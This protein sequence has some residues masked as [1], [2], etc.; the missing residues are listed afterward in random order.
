MQHAWGRV[1]VRAARRSSR[2]TLVT[3]SVACQLRS[4]A[5]SHV[6]RCTGA[7][8]FES[9]ESTPTPSRFLDLADDDKAKTDDDAQEGGDAE[10]SAEDVDGEG[11]DG[12]VEAD[13]IADVN[14]GGVE[15]NDE[16]DELVMELF[17]ENPLKW[18]PTVLARKFHLAKAR[19]EAIIWMKR[20]EAE[21][22][23]DEF[24]AKVQEAKDK[25][26]KETQ[27][28]AKKLKDAEAAGNE[29][30]VARLTKRARQEEDATKPDEE[31]SASEEAVLMGHDDEA[32]RNPDFFFLSDE[33]E[34]YP[35]LV[36]RMGK[37]G[38]TDQVY[39]E[40]ALELQRLAGNN[41]IT[42]QKSF[43]NPKNGESKAKF[44]LAVK[45][46][47]TKKK[48]LLVRDESRTLRL[49]TNEEVLPRTWVRRPA[50]FR[51]LD[52]ELA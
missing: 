6:A 50:Y 49:A 7:V 48:H 43:A 28:Q 40:E 12:D 47:T 34:G 26:Q 25:A 20:M 10:E 29:K 46:I 32:F 31:L 36:R 52:K 3:A 22:S 19:V 42:L 5:P 13:A 1:L 30:E 39:P 11:K 8:R 44:R 27:E 21:L 23:P 51:G 41:K 4:S 9:S 15:E 38:H 17:M 2:S 16:L 45:D 35:P 18:T 24:R 37:H 14:K 33:F